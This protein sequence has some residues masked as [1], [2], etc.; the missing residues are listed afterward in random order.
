[1]T[2]LNRS[3]ILVTGGAGFIGSHL[4]EK[5]LENP[6]N[7]VICVDNFLTSSVRNIQ[8][9]LKNPNFQF[10]RF[11]VTEPFDLET[12]SELG[13]FQVK[14]KG[15]QE[16]Y[17]MACPT[18][19]K[20]FDKHKIA[21]LRA[22]SIGTIRVL[23]MAVKYKAKVLLA[24]TSVVYGE[25]NASKLF[26][27]DETGNIDHLSPRACYDEG[28]RF[29][30]TIFETYKQVHGLDTKIA[31]VF[32]TYG[33]KMPLFDGHLIPDFILNA[34]ENKSLV[35]Y[36]KESFR[37]SLI[38]VDDVVDGLIRLMKA[39][40]DVGPVN[41]G[42]DADLLMSDVAKKIIEMTGSSSQIVFDKPLPFLTELGLPDTRKA[43]DALGWIPLVRL[44]YGLQK[45]IEYIEANKILLTSNSVL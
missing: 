29:A 23:D 13:Q 44:E 8:P 41:I 37:T 9:F 35:I 42:S 11:D 43:K 28:K 18:A 27:E 33:P 25:R 19:I 4:C 24:S 21:T 2:D 7:N 36:G 10:L 15:V 39:Q 3:N 6:R 20:D 17:H 45:T 34:L 5:L 38:Y 22:N 40:E 14:F 16:I 1:M 31:R 32:R 26:K 12:F 30:E